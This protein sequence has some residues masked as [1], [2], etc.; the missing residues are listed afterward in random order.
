MRFEFDCARCNSH[1]VHVQHSCACRCPSGEVL[2]LRVLLLGDKSL[3][4]TLLHN[5]SRERVHYSCLQLYSMLSR[6]IRVCNPS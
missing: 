5:I 1:R 4:Q 2:F 6:L 3:E